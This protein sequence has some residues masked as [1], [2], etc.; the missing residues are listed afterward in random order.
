MSRRLT[1]G[2][3]ALAVVFALT[4]TG[5][6]AQT[7][8]VKPNAA[9]LI[10]GHYEGVAKS[11]LRGDIP[12]T[13][14]LLDESGVLAGVIKTPLGDIPV[15]GGGYANGTLR[16]DFETDGDAG[17]FVARRTND[18]ASW[19]GTFTLFD[20]AG[21]VA[22]KRTG[23]TAYAPPAELR[24]TL[25][26][27]AAAWREDLRFL[28]AELPRRHKN[29]FHAITREQFARAVA[30]LDRRIPALTAQ[31]IVA[32]L[33]RL[34]AMIGD[35]HT[36]L[37]LPRAYG[38]VPLGLFWFGDEL[39]VTR[40]T[41]AYRRALGARLV[42]VGGVG[43]ADLYARQQPYISQDESEGFRRGAS[44]Y[45][46]IIPALLQAL[47]VAAEPTHA[48]YTF[49]GERGRR[50]T[51]D[52]PATGRDTK[53]AWVYPFKQT[54]L[55]LQHPDEPLWYEPLEGGRTVYLNFNAYPS[56]A[57]FRKFAQGL[58]AY[59]DTHQTK[60]LI[61]DLRQNG[62]GDFTKGRDFIISEIVKRPALMR[63]ESLYVLIGRV[64][65]SAGMTNATDFRKD[66]R[67]VLVGEPT[68]ARPN[69]YQE[70]RYFKLPNSHLDVSVSTLFYKFQE[71]DTPGVMPDK[72]IP[73]LWAANRDGRDPALAWILAQPV[74]E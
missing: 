2:L 26:L 14:E 39:R 59:L 67:A 7:P 15:T 5:A 38:R 73:P 45:Y 63:P 10:S 43:V 13:I 9:E 74:K 50:F 22:L 60:R 42:S 66:A 57:A 32:G 24:Q 65:Y 61:V 46:T 6:R 23:A 30:D 56:R 49:A 31:Q 54:P 58:F 16:I 72:F 28:A 1:A 12:L 25:D 44:A 19:A 48:R 34:T 36:D 29:A 27:S 35:G 4:P 69:G 3:L 53:A 47:G 17:A 20:D 21:A 33:L 8:S 52:L 18:A 70:N 37:N 68:G 51:L 41:P 64:T 55:Y 71:A 11:R 40:T 62:G